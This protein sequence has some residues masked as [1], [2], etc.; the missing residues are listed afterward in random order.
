ALLDDPNL[1]SKAWIWRQYDQLVQGN[2]ILGP[3]GDAALVR[4]KREDGTP[5]RKALALSVDCNP[6]FC[7]LDPR[8]GT[9][10][11]V[12]E[13]ARN[14]A[15][16]GARPLALTNCL[17]FGNPERPEIMWEFAEATR[18]LGD[19]LT[20]GYGLAPERAYPAVLGRLLRD[21]G[22][23]IR[24]VNAGV[25][26]DTSAGGLTRLPW[27]LEQQPDALVVALGGN[28]GLRGLSP[29]G[30]RE[31]LE[32]IVET[33]KAQGVPVL[34]LGL[35]MPPNFGPDY[36]EEFEGLYARVAEELD[37]PLVPFMLEGVAGDPG[38]NQGD[39]IHP[40]AEGQ[41]RVAAHVLPSL[42][43]LLEARP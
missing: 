13:A 23:P 39:G 6:R 19:S 24:V 4:V 16:T 7:W 37:V 25:S 26:G 22:R 12:A 42:R 10:A 2:T 21:E 38:L 40:N 3:G 5:T 29:A 17:N 28:D 30:T 20:A 8:A 33:A 31:N 36:T 14:V 34:L 15:C 11:A 41:A 9:I 32:R 18:G 35:R 43:E 27:L 1:G